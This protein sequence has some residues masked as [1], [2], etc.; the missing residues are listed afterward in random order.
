MIRSRSRVP[1]CPL[2]FFILPL[3]RVAAQNARSSSADPASAPLTTPDSA[4]IYRNLEYQPQ[5]CVYFSHESQASKQEDPEPNAGCGY[6]HFIMIR[7]P[8]LI[9]EKGR[10]LK[11]Q[12]SRQPGLLQRDIRKKHACAVCGLHRVSLLSSSSPLWVWAGQGSDLQGLRDAASSLP[13]ENG[14]CKTLPVSDTIP[15]SPSVTRPGVFVCFVQRP[16]QRWPT[17]SY[18]CRRRHPQACANVTC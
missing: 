17:R 2:L 1:P 10:G 13:N 12:L 3:V 16:L 8:N 15:T 7:P 4:W 14:H 11:P 9:Y 18:S 6:W 5:R